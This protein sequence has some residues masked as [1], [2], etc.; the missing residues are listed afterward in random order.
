MALDR[1][2]FAG[3]SILPQRIVA[4]VRRN[5]PL[6]ALDAAIVVPAY[7]GP[8]VLRFDGSVPSPYWGSF[9]IFLPIAVAVHLAANTLFG[10]YGQMWRYASV[11]EARRLVLA[12]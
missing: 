4:H 1:H 9:R 2:L 8:L 10:L 7:L 6:A 3:K 11:Q 12:R 5:V